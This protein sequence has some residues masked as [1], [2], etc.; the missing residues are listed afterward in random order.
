MSWMTKHLVGTSGVLELF[1]NVF[2][3]NHSMRCAATDGVERLLLRI[4]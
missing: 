3:S 1:R 4:D 2:V